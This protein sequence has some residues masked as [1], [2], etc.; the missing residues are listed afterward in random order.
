MIMNE[1]RNI[2][3]KVQEIGK[4]SAFRLGLQV[5]GGQSELSWFQLGPGAPL[6]FSEEECDDWCGLAL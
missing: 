5:S 6:Y 1:T 2:Y 3:R 4:A